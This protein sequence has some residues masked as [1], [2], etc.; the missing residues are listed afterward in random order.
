MT[1]GPSRSGGTSETVRGANRQRNVLTYVA[2]P[3]S[4]FARISLDGAGQRV[5]KVSLSTA[6]DCQARQATGRGT[7][8]ERHRMWF[9]VRDAPVEL[10]RP[11]VPGPTGC[12]GA[13]AGAVGSSEPIDQVHSMSIPAEIPAEIPA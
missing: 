7:R 11:V 4:G 5:T 2:K 8:P 9:R 10:L 1:G 6:C 3:C 13:L 12:R